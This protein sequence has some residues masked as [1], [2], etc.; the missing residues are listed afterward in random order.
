MAP[1]G[2]TTSTPENPP[3]IPCPGRILAI[4]PGSKRIGLAMS[5]PSQ[6]IAQPLA[7]LSRRVGKRFPLQSLKV[8]LDEHE[9]VGI[10]VG[11]P[12]APDG[13][14][15]E[16]AKNSRD[17]GATLNAK[18]KLPIAFWDERMTTARALSAVKDLGG[19]VRGRK[20]EVDGLAATVLLQAFLDSRNR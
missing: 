4:D 1:P 18:T 5:D 14:E 9:P 2:A 10:V 15:D 8:H 16:R 6:T 17:L 20:A 7:T 11:L 19:K 3:A 12:I 13:S